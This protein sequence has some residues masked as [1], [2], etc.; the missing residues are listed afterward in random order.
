MEPAGIRW[1]DWVIAKKNILSNVENSFIS[2]KIDSKIDSWRLE[3]A[4]F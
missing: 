1:R 3:F 2:V 4:R